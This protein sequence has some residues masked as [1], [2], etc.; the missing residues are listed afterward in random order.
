VTVTT[1][2]AYNVAPPV[3]HSQ[4]E[5]EIRHVIQSESSCYQY[6]LL[7][8][9]AC[10]RDDNPAF[11]IKSKALAA[12]DI[13]IQAIQVLYGTMQHNIKKLSDK[14]IETLMV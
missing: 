1:G 11:P 2:L 13:N 6:V 12:K 10:H 9:H 3:E 5:E 4:I 14:V 7:I 8:H